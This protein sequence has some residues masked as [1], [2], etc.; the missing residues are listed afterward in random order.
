MFSDTTLAGTYIFYKLMHLYS[1]E[2]RNYM[3]LS[4]KNLRCLF[5][6]DPIFTLRVEQKRTNRLNFTYIYN[7]CM[8]IQIVG[9]P[10]C[11]TLAGTYIF[12]K[13]MHLYSRENINKLLDYFGDNR[14]NYNKD[15][16]TMVCKI[17][18]IF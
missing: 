7:V 5:F 10:P 2:N 1:R 16:S 18:N 3:C 6:C 12:Y 11:P 4:P 8:Y 9:T 14:F 15:E 17:N 13:L